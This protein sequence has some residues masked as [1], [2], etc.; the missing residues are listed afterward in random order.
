VMKVCARKAK[1]NDRLQYKHHCN[2][3]VKVPSFE[4]EC[5]PCRP[6]IALLM[7]LAVMEGHFLMRGTKA[8]TRDRTLGLS[9]FIPAKPVG[10]ARTQVRWG[11]R[12]EGES[13]ERLGERLGEEKKVRQGRKGMGYEKA[14]GKEEDDYEGS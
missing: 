9:D 12:G 2:L 5:M 4:L 3:I 8:F 1:H 7:S 14:R 11:E 13:T 6:Y 10:R